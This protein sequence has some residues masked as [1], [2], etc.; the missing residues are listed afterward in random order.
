[1]AAV[2][3][4][5]RVSAEAG[6]W[7][8]R[9]QASDL[10][11]ADEQTF[12]NWLAANPAH[13]AAFEHATG[14]WENLGALSRGAYFPDEKPQHQISRRALIA[15]SAGFIIGSGVPFL[16]GAANAQTFKTSV[17][18]CKHVPLSDGSLLLLDTN[19]SVAIGRDQ[20]V[21]SIILHYGRINCR[22][23]AGGRPFVVRA[24]Q[25]LVLGDHPVF[26]LYYVENYFSAV[27]IKGKAM[28]NTVAG[29]VDLSPGERAVATAEQPLRCDWPPMSSLTAWQTGHLVFQDEAVTDAVREMNR[30]SAIKLEVDD[31]QIAAQHISGGYLAGDNAGFAESLTHL[32]PVKV[33]Q[34]SGIIKL[35]NGNTI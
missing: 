15:A 14:V 22:V 21:R 1:M 3:F 8:A 27:L 26:D 7:L 30:Y 20:D 16:R 4:D 28:V 11:A 24:G 34:G 35:M 33:R 6:A 19:T 17:G 9:L 18:E 25:R 2:F 32:F 13:A 31:P 29:R 12:H 23:A 10:S 5:E